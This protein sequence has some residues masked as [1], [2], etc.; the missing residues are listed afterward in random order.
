MTALLLMFSI[1]PFMILM[2]FLLSDYKFFLLI[3]GL[4]YFIKGGSSY[5]TYICLFIAFLKFIIKRNNKFKKYKDKTFYTYRFYTNSDFSNF[6]NFRNNYGNYESNSYES[7]SFQYENAC[8]FFGVLPD[9][10]MEQKKKAYKEMAKKYHPDLN[11]SPEA[12][13]MTKKINE[14]WDIIEKYN[15]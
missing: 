8:K 9:A 3:A 6:N 10:T 11:K 7:S 15:N 13:E 5:F 12:E 4:S 1:I 2:I 14:N